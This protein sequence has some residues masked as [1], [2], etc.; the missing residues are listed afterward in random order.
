M[1]RDNC[2]GK[3]IKHEYRNYRN[4]NMLYEFVMWILGILFILRTI[5][6]KLFC[7]KCSAY[8]CK[9][10]RQAEIRTNGVL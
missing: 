10:I 5:I 9:S 6:M 3:E 1:S 7:R 2:Y 4:K 8:Q